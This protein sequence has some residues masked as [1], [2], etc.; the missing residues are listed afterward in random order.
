MT[1]N[2]PSH[3]A[4]MPRGAL[5]R[6]TAVLAAVLVVG[7][8][9]LVA[10]ALVDDSTTAVADSPAASA[11][12][13]ERPRVARTSTRPAAELGARIDVDPLTIAALATANARAQRRT[14][15]TVPVVDP[16]ILV[17]ADTYT[18]NEQG[19]R[20]VLLQE[21]LG[22]AVDGRYGHAT[23]RAHLAAVEFVGLPT[24][25]VP[26][27]ALPPGPSPDEWEALRQ[28]ESNGNYAITNPSG[29]YRGAYQFDRTT[30][31]SVASRHATHLVGVDPAAAAPADQDYMALALYSERGASPWP[32]CGR[33]LS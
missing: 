33:H 3:R 15:P 26:V 2:S 32:H 21:T 6:G 29:K 30:W 13:S 7:G 18:W 27:P 22:V 16:V 31:D 19:P 17:L 5:R 1:P 4:G 28:C 10:R 12:A 9:P 11:S 8:T 20:V 25:T 24:S 14:E 23:H